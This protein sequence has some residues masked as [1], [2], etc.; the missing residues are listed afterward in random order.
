VKAQRNQIERALDAADPAIRLF[1]LYG[2]DEAGSRALAARLGKA[3]GGGAER[4]DLTGTALKADPARLPDEAAAISLFGDPRWIRVEPAGDEMFEAASA[5]LDAPRAG[6]PVAVLAGALRKD[7]KLLKLAT[8]HPAALVFASYLPEGGEADRLVLAMARDVGLRMRP[9]VGRRLA[10][11]TGGDRAL[12]GQEL[13]KLALYVDAAP[14]RPGDIDHD[15][16][17]ALGAATEEGD[18]GRLVGAV[19]SGKLDAADAELARLAGQGIEGV[20]LIRAVFR[21]LLLLAQLRAQVAGGDSVDSVMS[22]AGNSIFWK[23]KGE[24]AQQLARWTP[25]AIET[26]L[27][28]LSEAERQVKASGTLGTVAVSEELLAISRH[29]ARMR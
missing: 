9:D 16:L 29:A 6:N 12:I 21:R 7:S 20:P 28:R 11:A 2:P 5:L 10:S 22:A 4:I 17:D 27:G 1:L 19:L 26:A 8:A 23:E 25:P 24:V 3:V 14:D 13:E 15:A 18:L